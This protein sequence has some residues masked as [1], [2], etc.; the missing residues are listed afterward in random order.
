LKFVP[1]FILVLD[2]CVLYFNLSARSF[3]RRSQRDFE[4]RGGTCSV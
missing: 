4:S 1:E 2:K 3:T